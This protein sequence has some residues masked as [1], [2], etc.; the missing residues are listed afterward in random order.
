MKKYLNQTYFILCMLFFRYLWWIN[1]SSWRVA[2]EL[3]RWPAAG[4]GQCTPCCP[5]SP[6]SPTL[7]TQDTSPLG[8][9]CPHY[10]YS[11][12]VIP[13]TS[14]FLYTTPNYKPSTNLKLYQYQVLI[15]FCI[16][17][18]SIV[19]QFFTIYHSRKFGNS[20]SSKLP[21]SILQ[22]LQHCTAAIQAIWK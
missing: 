6:T 14:C 20:A 7:A 1:C 19:F 4:A 11:S 17:I 3:V 9:L 10:P 8:N 22:Y 18:K 5:P 13:P 2:L 15:L 12:H 16:H 21:R